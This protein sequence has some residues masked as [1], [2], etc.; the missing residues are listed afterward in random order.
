MVTGEPY[1]D[2]KGRWRI[3]GD[4]NVPVNVTFKANKSQAKEIK[5]SL[6]QKKIH[7]VLSSMDDNNLGPLLFL[8]YINDL[9]NSTKNLSTILFADDTNLFCSGKDINELECNINAELV[10]VQEWLTLN[11]LTLNIKKSNYIIF[12]TAKKQ[13]KKSLT[14]K[15]DNKEIQRV[16]KTKFLGIII[17]QHLTWN[18]HIDYITKKIIKATGIRF[19]VSQVLL[20]ILYNSLIYPGIMGLTGLRDSHVRV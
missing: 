17:D 10:N 8:I 11:Q 7:V 14:L 18:N 15:L 13:L 16:D 3:G 9:N 5:R 2:I 19:Y 20:K 6:M 4:I 1:D 12:R